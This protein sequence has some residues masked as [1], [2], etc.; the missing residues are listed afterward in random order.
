M[1]D[2]EELWFCDICYME[3]EHHPNNL[4]CISDDTYVKKFQKCPI[5]DKLQPN[6]EHVAKH[7]S[8]ELKDLVESFE[9]PLTCSHCGYQS[10]KNSQLIA[11]HIA[12][13]HDA[14]KPYISDKNVIIS[15][16]SAWKI[17][18]SFESFVHKRVL[19]K[20]H[21]QSEVVY[22]TLELVFGF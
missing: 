22:S 5:C 19:V 1:E 10:E 16:R 14:I 21:S 9:D 18:E 13:S 11:L 6:S 20:Y 7:F 15:K 12:I 3:L 2:F 17:G 8:L 4:P